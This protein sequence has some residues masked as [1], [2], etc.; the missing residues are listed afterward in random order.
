MDEADRKALK[1]MLAA[2]KF[3]PYISHIRFPHYKNLL[4]D[5]KI[6]L[7]FPITALVG[8]NGTN[9]SSI[10]RAIQG[11]PEG[12]NLGIY[13]FS[14]STD[15]IAENG[16]RNA[17]IYGYHHKGAGKVVEV[18]KTRV[19]KDEDP[20]YWE[21]SRAI[22]SYSMA[23]FEGPVDGNKNRT[24]WDTI[25]KPVVYLDFRQTISAF[26]RCFYYG[27]N[28]GESYR[29]R[30][31]FLRKRSPR[32]LSAIDSNATS[33][34][35]YSERIVRGVN[36]LLNDEERK[37]ASIILGRDYSEIRWIRPP[38]STSAV[39][40][41]CSKRPTCLTRK[42]SPAAANLPSSAWSS[43]WST[44]T[45]APSFFWTSRRSRSI[46]ALRSG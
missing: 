27:T 20:D 14:T 32:L 26:D 11:S 37:A 13:W 33:V 8:A 34:S 41:A 22:T 31:D 30:K 21:P 35:Y 19:K 18:L 17:F 40:R 42:L 12:E 15:P 23:R 45:R 5:L 29:E 36:R 38:S 28:D 39:R 16:A 7:D 43:N 25:T 6:D 24:R 46:R 44:P 3:D 1:A 4:P 9:K 2:R 10:L